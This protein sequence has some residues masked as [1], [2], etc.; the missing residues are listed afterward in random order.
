ML[1]A[2]ASML[3]VSRQAATQFLHLRNL[4]ENLFAGCGERR[5]PV[6]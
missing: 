6:F 1:A 2:G 5:H 4:P 3:G